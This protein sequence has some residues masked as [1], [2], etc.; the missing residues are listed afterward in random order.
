MNRLLPFFL[1]GAVLLPGCGEMARLPESA[2]VGPSP[3]LP[4]PRTGLLPTVHIAPAEGWPQG[5][6]PV[7]AADLRVTAFATGLDHPRW[8]YLLP[9][10]DVLVAESNQ[11]QPPEG[12][13]EPGIK[14]WAMKGVMK[15]AGAGVPSADRITLLRDADGDGVAETRSVLLQGLH[16]PFGMALVGGQL[17]VANADGVVRFPFTPGATRITAPPTAVTPLP[18]GHN[19]HWTKNLLASRDGRTLYATVG[20]NSNVGE[21]GLEMEEGRAAIWTIDRASGA[22]RLFA[23]GLRN[24]NGLAWEPSTGVLWTVVNERDELG[25]DLVPDYLT[26]VREGA[27]YGWP[28]SYWGSHVDARVQPPRPDLVARAVVP[29]YALGNHVAPLGLAFADGRLPPFARG[30]FVG[31]HGSWNRQP[32]AGYKV[33]FIPFEGGKPAGPP[34][35]VLTGF[36]S[37]DGKAWGRPVGVALDA[38]GALLVADDVGN[39][40]WRV[41]PAR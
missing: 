31:L 8:L 18:G 32:L 5:R 4:E 7:P 11:P 23:T 10:G 25:S 6:Q 37:P 20:S 21:H 39:A 24:P 41:A 35:D 28:W 33:V 14:G 3:Q 2:T 26:S 1:A 12:Q 19:H 22:K 36:L 27:F 30:A 34:R 38:R 16:S 13:G 15:R 40:V 29:D 9:N 17:Y